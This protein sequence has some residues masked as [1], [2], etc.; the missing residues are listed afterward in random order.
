MTNTEPVAPAP[1]GSG[2]ASTQFKKVIIIAIVAPLAV[3]LIIILVAV[4][5][6]LADVQGVAETVRMLRDLLMV[7]IALELGLIFLSVAVLLVQVARLLNVLTE[8][9]QPLLETTQETVQT[10]QSTVQFA[11]RNVLNPV[12]DIASSAAAISVLF[13]GLFGLCRAYTRATKPKREDHAQ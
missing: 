12:I 7:F 8:E 11:G 10:A 6:A 2:T 13:S 4:L 3:M 1:A 9:V 5:A